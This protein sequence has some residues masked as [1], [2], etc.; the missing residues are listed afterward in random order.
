MP[1]PW[2]KSV[3]FCGQG[4]GIVYDKRDYTA[5]GTLA[6]FIYDP[7]ILADFIYDPRTPT[8]FIYYR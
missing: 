2:Y 6:D 7:R 8:D 1:G 3:K 5:D 4:A